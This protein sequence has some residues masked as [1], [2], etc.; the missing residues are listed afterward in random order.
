M[1]VKGMTGSAII[2]SSDSVEVVEPEI[3]AVWSQFWCC[4][5]RWNCRFGSGRWFFAGA[6]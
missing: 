4:S 3:C 2:S 5:R 6:R 1:L